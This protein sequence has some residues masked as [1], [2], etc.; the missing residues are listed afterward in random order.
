LWRDAID[1]AAASK[2]PELCES[3]VRFFVSQGRKDCFAAALYTCY[4]Y[5]SPDV[6]LE[7]AWR[8]GMTDFAM[9]FLIQTMREYHV[10][11]NRLQ[12]RVFPPVA[13]P[14]AHGSHGSLE[15]FVAPGT[16][17]APIHGSGLEFGGFVPVGSPH[18]SMGA[19]GQPPVM[20]GGGVP[21]GMVPVGTMPPGM[22]PGGM[23]PQPPFGWS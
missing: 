8:N 6:A 17:S 22:V 10:T 20:M 7:L 23:Q 4:D 14:D 18:M 2:K 5:I 1:T 3:L 12:E 15:G 16:A 9:P 13:A 21:P 11:I 19:P